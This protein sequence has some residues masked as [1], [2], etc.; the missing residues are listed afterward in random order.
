[1]GLIVPTTTRALRASC[2]SAAAN[3]PAAVLGALSTRPCRAGTIPT[4]P[5]GET[6]KPAFR[7]GRLSARRRLSKYRSAAGPP[8]CS[9]DLPCPG[10]ASIDRSCHGVIAHADPP[11]TAER[12]E[13]AA[14]APC[15]LH[16]R[17][18]VRGHAELARA[19]PPAAVAGDENDR[20]ALE[21]L[22]AALEEALRGAGRHPAYLDAVD[23]DA[24]GDPSGGAGESE[25]EHR[26]GHRDEHEQDHAPLDAHARRSPPPTPSAR[27]NGPCT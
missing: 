5:P 14:A 18:P 12:A 20:N 22:R 16:C 3:R 25:P 19:Q 21:V 17:V 6:A 7:A 11:E 1:P 13:T 9:F 23:A 24:V 2:E 4:V 15:D 10:S 8:I 27:G 26:A